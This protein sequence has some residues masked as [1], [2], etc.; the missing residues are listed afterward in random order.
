MR[1]IVIFDVET[2]GKD[3]SKDQIIELSI[4]FGFGNESKVWKIRP[5]IEISPGAMEVHGI[6]MSDLENSPYFSEVAGEIQ[7]ILDS[8]NVWVGYN[9]DFDINI[10]QAEMRRNDLPEFD[11][12]KKLVIDP[13]K[14]WKHLEPRTLTDAYRRFVGRELDGAHSAEVDTVATGEVLVA[15]VNHFGLMDTPLEQL[16]LLCEPERA[17]WIGSSRHLKWNDSGVPVVNFGAKHAD[18]PVMQVAA[19]NPGYLNWVKT[20]DFPSHVRDIV[21]RALACAEEISVREKDSS[22]VAERKFI[23][24][25]KSNYGEPQIINRL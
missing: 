3:V 23:N 9:L 17:S 18:K 20:Q 12:T 2:T 19:E 6:S 7:N 13:Y 15:M 25:L 11:L 8:N 5:T 21:D 4:T 10:L 1:D 22:S 16:A 24:W 14:L